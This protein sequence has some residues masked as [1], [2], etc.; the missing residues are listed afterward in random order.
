VFTSA[1]ATAIFAF[2]QAG[3]GLVGI[4]DH[5]GSDR[6]NDGIDSP[7]IWNA[8]DPN[9]YFGVR[10]GVAGDA[11]NNIVQ[12]STNVN[13]A[14]SDSVT[15]GPVGVVT[16]LAFHNGTTM[17]LYPLV[18]ASVRGEVW[19]TGVPQSSPS[20]VMAA[21]SV[22]GAGHVFFLGDSSP[23]D[24]GSANPG[25]SS[26][27]DGWGEV[28]ATDSTLIMNA[29]LWATRRAPAGD[30]TAPTVNLATPN[31]GENWKAGTTHAIVWSATDNVAVASVDLAWSSTGGASF[32]NVIATGVANSGS[33]DW[34]VPNAPTGTARVRV[35]ARDAAGNA[36]TD[37]SSAN[38]TISLWTITAIAG[39]GGSVT[40]TGSV[41]VVQGGNAGFTITPAAT[42]QIVNI[43][44]DALPVGAV[45]S[46]AFSNVSAD[47]SL[48]A[49]F[50]DAQAPA[51]RLITPVGGE[52][53]YPGSLRS[54]LWVATDN[55]GVDS[56][57]VDWSSQ[58]AGG[59]W[60]RVAHG[61]AN[62]GTYNWTVPAANTINAFVRIT[63]F[64]AAL[65][66][67]T[68]A[69]DSAFRIFGPPV[70][71]DAG[72]PPVL[73]LARPAPNPGASATLMRFTLPGQGAARIEVVDVAGRQV[74]MKAATLGAGVHAWSW[75]GRDG[76]GRRA[77]AGV[78]FVRLVTPWGV[79]NE[80]L[81]RLR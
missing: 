50:A 22:Y 12:T 15:H 18:N 62:S 37:S 56:V 60:I 29:T 80:R 46:Y 30:T 24:D 14:A 13:A 65:H 43:F 23:A 58:G 74:W 9:H 42:Y 7:A 32:G 63:A 52:V 79:K 69:S 6:N 67:T 26:I 21:S 54:I 20:S 75:D 40:P 53:W 39:P 70:G 73:A 25:N 36:R 45:A 17:T 38:F 78:Y 28:G 81:T 8:L 72:S 59:P 27:Y 66:S 71:T 19:M 4:A 3:G 11:N 1:E 31:G 51:A 2:L 61:L 76:A 33:Y 47:H 77:G 44:V 68:A 49:T 34:T 41:P 57:N 55:V 64:D 10:F 35:L 16:G 5:Y 48:A